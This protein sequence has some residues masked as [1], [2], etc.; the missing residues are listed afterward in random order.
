MPANETTVDTINIANLKTVAE[1]GSHSIALSF[2]NSVA[3]QQSMNQ[4][5]VAGGG[6][7]MKRLVELDVEEAAAAAPLLQELVKIAQTTPPVTE[8]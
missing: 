5:T 6:Q 1:A 2:Q 3:N 8:E 7:I 4:I